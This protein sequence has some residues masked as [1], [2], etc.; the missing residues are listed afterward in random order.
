MARIAPPPCAS[1]AGR[2][3]ATPARQ[4]SFAPVLPAPSSSGSGPAR[5]PPS[6]L[7]ALRSRVRSTQVGSNM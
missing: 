3:W 4:V 6:M 5:P 7:S 1:K 2:S